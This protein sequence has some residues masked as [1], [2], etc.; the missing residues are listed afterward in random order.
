[1]TQTK[2]KIFSLYG[3]LFVLVGNCWVKNKESR[4]LSDPEINISTDCW[5]TDHLRIWIHVI[6]QR[7]AHGVTKRRGIALLQKNHWC[8]NFSSQCSSILQIRCHGVIAWREV[9]QDTLHLAWINI[10]PVFLLSSTKLISI[11]WKRL[12]CVIG[13][14]VSKT[15]SFFLLQRKSIFRVSQFR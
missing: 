13:C 2:P 14:Q 5:L 4:L 15:S 10:S 12:R 11:L 8:F 3:V 7:W 6:S 1:M 9:V